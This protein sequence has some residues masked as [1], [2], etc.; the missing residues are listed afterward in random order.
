M[1]E[2]KPDGIPC[3]LAQGKVK[4]KPKVWLTIWGC[5]VHYL[6][7]SGADNILRL[8]S[9]GAVNNGEG[10]RFSFSKRLET[11]HIDGRE[12]NKHVRASLLLNKSKALGI[13]EPFYLPSFH[14]RLSLLT[15]LYIA[16]PT[17]ST[18][19]L[20]QVSLLLLPNDWVRYAA[21]A[22]PENP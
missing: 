7:S 13:I 11:F 2:A 14:P 9:F 19:T 1:K 16:F 18:I 15:W 22:V 21:V 17:F 6:P 10:H 5:L 20:S 4:S 12:M 8:G 3:L